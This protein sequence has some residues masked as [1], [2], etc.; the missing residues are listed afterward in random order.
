VAINMVSLAPF[1]AT[2]G[3]SLIGEYIPVMLG[4]IAFEN[5]VRCRLHRV[6]IRQDLV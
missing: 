6:V 5:Q 4:V 1:F 3:R 2:M